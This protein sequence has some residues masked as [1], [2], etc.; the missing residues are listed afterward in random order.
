MVP[1]YNINDV[2]LVKEK[3]N[4]EIQIG[5]DLV[6]IGDTG[7]INGIIITHRVVD[8]EKHDNKKFSY[9]TKGLMNLNMDP[10][11]SEDQILGVVVY[12]IQI[13]SIISK[14]I[15]NIYGFFLLVFTP[16]VILIFI[17]IKELILSIKE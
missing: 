4:D 17:N 8:I 3:E 6:Y 11:V 16:L 2:I 12:K 10:V 14:I 15:N 5:D 9:Y 7:E 13:L 1:V